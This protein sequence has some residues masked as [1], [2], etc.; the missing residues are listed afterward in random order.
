MKCRAL[1]GLAI[2]LAGAARA[3]TLES[4]GL[5]M[6]LL[7]DRSGSI[8]SADR[9]VEKELV[10]LTLAMLARSARGGVRHRLGVVSFGSAAHIDLPLSAVDQSALQAIRAE[11]A[12]ADSGRS[13][14]NTNFPAACDAAA[15]MLAGAEGQRRRSVLLVTDGRS[16]VPGIPN[17]EIVRRLQRI[18]SSKLAATT[19]DVLILGSKR[20]SASWRRLSGVQIQVAS[21]RSDALTTLHRDVGDLLGTPGERQRIRGMLDTIDLPPYLDLVVFDVVRDSRD[22]SGISVFPPGA[23]RPL[24]ARTPGVEEVRLGDAVSTLAVHRPAAGAWTF[25]KRSA[26]SHVR[27]LMQ[28]FFP[29]GVLVRPDSHSTLRTHERV[30]VGYGLVDS[31]G[32]MLKELPSFP[33]SVD[34]TLARP[35]ARRI[36]LPMKQTSRSGVYRAAPAECDL[37]GRY[38]TEVVVS[39][40]VAGRA[41]R[42]FEDRWSG[43]SVLA[44]PA[45]ACCPPRIAPVRPARALSVTAVFAAAALALMALL[46][47]WRWYVARRKTRI[48]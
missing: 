31:N 9:R 43:F 27:V 32:A 33:L 16:Y 19:F 8:T 13:L 4:A 11:L 38:W 36:P 34:L 26:D 47:L 2:S 20:D 45:A 48:A 28:Q 21:G 17:D 30:A 6:V 7:I 22:G 3:N 46:A 1:F 12:S 42:V 23:R 35:D 39:A 10:D 14:G 29:R 41:V 44:S 37:P 25:R 40:N 15:D 18:V 5:D 24:D